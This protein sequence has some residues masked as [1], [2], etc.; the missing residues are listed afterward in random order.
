[1]LQQLAD[2]FGLRIICTYGTAGHGRGAIDGLPTFGVKNILRKDIVTC[3]LFF[4][5]SEAITNYLSKRNPQFCYTNVLAESVT[6]TRREECKSLVIPNCMKQ[7][8]LVFQSEKLYCRKNSFVPANRAF[9]F[10]SKIAQMLKKRLV[11]I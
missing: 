8:L 11:I 2:E 6:A 9:S 4:N 7:Y 1:M 3:D 10:I 5:S